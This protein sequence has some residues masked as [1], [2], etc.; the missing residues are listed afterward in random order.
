MCEHV[1]PV[2]PREHDIRVISPVEVKREELGVPMVLM[3]ETVFV[4]KVLIGGENVTV[5]TTE[6][7]LREAPA[8]SFSVHQSNGPHTDDEVPF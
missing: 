1:D 4:Q 7:V 6:F 2:C 8:A 5:P 3:L